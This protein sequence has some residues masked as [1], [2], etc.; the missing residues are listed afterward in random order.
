MV[1]KVELHG[2]GKSAKSGDNFLE[3]NINT[4][5]D[6]IREREDATIIDVKPLDYELEQSIHYLVVYEVV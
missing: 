6:R 2:A 5:L 3:K 4:T 1:K